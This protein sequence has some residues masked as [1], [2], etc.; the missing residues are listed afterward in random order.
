MEQVRTIEAGTP[1][2]RF[3]RGWHCLGLAAGFREG[4]PHAVAAFGTKLVVFADSA[5]ALHVL[6]AYCRHMG[7]DLSQGT[8]KGD[9]VAC[10]FHDWRWGGDGRCARSLTPGGSRWRPGPGPGAPW[11]G[12]GSCSCGTT[13]RATR[14][15]TT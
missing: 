7:G 3:A 15:R 14:R 6:D 8:V 11:S 5:G 12:T 9:A 10:P 13:R 2:A 1:P 4:G